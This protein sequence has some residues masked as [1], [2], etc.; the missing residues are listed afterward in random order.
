MEEKQ[1]CEDDG[2]GSRPW[3]IVQKTPASEDCAYGSENGQAATEEK[4]KGKEGKEIMMTH[5]HP[6]SVRHHAHEK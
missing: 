5:S 4:S 3:L 6:G 1:N 2:G